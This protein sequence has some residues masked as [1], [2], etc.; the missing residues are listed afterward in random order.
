MRRNGF[1]IIETLIS[2]GILTIVLAVGVSY[3]SQQTQLSR[4]TQAH[5]EVQDKVRSVM[6]VITNDLQLVGSSRYVDANGTT[7]TLLNCS[8][9]SYCLN[10]ANGQVGY[11]DSVRLRYTT[12]LRDSA[13]ACRRIDYGFSNDD[14][15]RSD[16]ACSATDTDATT[17]LASSSNTLANNILAV[18]LRYKCS[19]GEEIWNYPDNTNC[20]SGSSYPRSAIVIVLGRSTMP[21]QGISSKQYAVSSWTVTCP[22]NYSCFSLTQQ[23]LLPNMKDQ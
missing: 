13:N 3:F 8:P 15:R 10:G 18:N 1:T 6:Q 14:F 23:V 5:S 4:Q 19:N 9:A 2:M 12:S 7:S 17:S 11:K 16:L 20:P 22:A 21:V